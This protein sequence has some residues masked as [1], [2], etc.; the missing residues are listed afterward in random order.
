MKTHNSLKS[1]YKN[2]CQKL[3]M[4]DTIYVA[5]QMSSANP[6]SGPFIVVNCRG[7]NS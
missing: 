6:A 2:R 7:D 3:G 1:Y 4:R 5:I